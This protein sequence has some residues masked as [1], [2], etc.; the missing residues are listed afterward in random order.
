[1]AARERSRETPYQDFTRIKNAV[2]IRRAARGH[3]DRD[4]LFTDP[5]FPPDWSSLTYVYSGDDKYER[6][7]FKR[8]TEICEQPTFIGVG[9]VIDEPFPWKQ[10]RQRG[11]FQAAVIIISLNVRFLDRLIPGY[12]VF[13]QNFDS[14]YIGAFRFTMWRFTEWVEIIIDDHLP[15]LDH[16]HFFCKV[17]GAPSEYWGALAEKA[18]AKCKKTFQA[19]E[20]GNMLDAL[21]DLTG[22][23]CEYYTPDVNPADNL[24]HIMYKS[25]INRSMMVCWRNDKRLTSTGFDLEESQKADNDYDE[26]TTEERHFLHLITATTKFPSTDGRLIEMLRL[27]CPF[28]KEPKW[29]GKYSDNDFNSWN[30]VT[31]EFKDKYRPLSRKEED[32][33]W[34]SMDDFRCNFGGLVIISSTE[35][36]NYEGLTVD[37]NYSLDNDFPLGKD[38]NKFLFGN[39]TRPLLNFERTS[40]PCEHGIKM[41]CDSRPNAGKMKLVKKSSFVNNCSVDMDI[42]GADRTVVLD[43]TKERL[44]ADDKRKMTEKHARPVPKGPPQVKERK[45]SQPLDQHGVTSPTA[46]SR[47]QSNPW[48]CKSQTS[49]PVDG[50]KRQKRAS[51]FLTQSEPYSSSEISLHI[52]T[53]LSVDDNG[54]P[55]SAPLPRNHSTGSLSSLT[56]INFLATKADFFRAHGRWRNILEYKDKWSRNRK[57]LSRSSIEAHSKSPRILFH[58][59]RADVSDDIISPSMQSKRHVLI[60]VLQDYRHG[61]STANSLLVPVGFC[62]YK[63]KNPDRDEKRHISKLQ[64]IG[65]V[66]GKPEMREV[67]ARFDLE[68]GSYFIVPYYVTQVHEGEYLIRILTEGDPPS[69]K[70]ACIIS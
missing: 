62:I 68:P 18:Y 67:N 70:A 40:S 53:T 7:V 34:L 51:S 27:R 36:F 12:K 17:I 57:G 9:G 59:S 44:K 33:Y 29:H 56:Q 22:C 13:E 39:Q 11:W 58:V 63:T 43:C 2:F 14:D 19:I 66:E 28:P 52:R 30:T 35:A 69:G 50:D 64:L 38:R 4:D 6:T 20:Y 41:F 55:Q 47:R 10:W 60:S 45:V 32:E 48:M 46:S 26:H 1:M 42:T 54:R 5:S 3:L 8:P 61:P 65:E 31:A 15:M 37:R 49:V 16:A 25:S 23:V 21:T 24:F